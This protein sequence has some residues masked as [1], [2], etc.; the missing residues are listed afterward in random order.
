MVRES[1]EDER[2]RVL[3]YQAGDRRAAAELVAAFHGFF[4]KT[5]ARWRRFSAADADDLYQEAV[6]SFLS[7]TKLFDVD[8]GV[9]LLTFVYRYVRRDVA[10][11][12]RRQRACGLRVNANL[13]SDTPYFATRSVLEQEA[14]RAARRP[15]F[16]SDRLYAHH[17]V[18]VEDHLASVRRGPEE[19][20][21]YV[22]ALAAQMDRAE[23]NERETLVIFRRLQGD[24]QPR[25]ATD[26]GVSRQAVHLNEAS[27]VK[28]LSRLAPE[29]R[30]LRLGHP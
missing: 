15:V 27:A 17:D 6:A 25:I 21:A 5:A 14:A 8:R 24:S 13:L 12:A 29:A 10:R 18:L 4:A 7:A 2:A 1:R 11:F 23:L 28:K 9:S 30:E 19:I 3:R 22:E 16:L 20:V 26:L